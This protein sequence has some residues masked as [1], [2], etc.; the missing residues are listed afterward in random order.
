MRLLH[1]ATRITAGST[2]PEPNLPPAK[3]RRVPEFK[4][5]LRIAHSGS[6]SV[7]QAAA[8]IEC[9]TRKQCERR[10]FVDLGP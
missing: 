7:V 10:Q 1:C 6:L 5:G 4:A 9:V 2:S 3:R 8:N